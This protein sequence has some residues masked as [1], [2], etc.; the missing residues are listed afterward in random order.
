MLVPAQLGKREVKRLKRIN[1]LS[2]ARYFWCGVGIQVYMKKLR[3]YLS[4]AI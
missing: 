3:A 4:F 1:D 2:T